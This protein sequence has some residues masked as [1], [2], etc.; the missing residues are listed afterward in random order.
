[1]LT[2]G[3]CIG[4]ALLPLYS[5][6]SVPLNADADKGSSMLIAQKHPK[7]DPWPT[8]SMAGLPLSRTVLFDAREMQT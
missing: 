6:S 5:A 3:S 7:S 1:M 4:L 2:V 8:K